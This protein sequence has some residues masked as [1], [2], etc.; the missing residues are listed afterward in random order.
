MRSRLCNAATGSFLPK[1]KKWLSWNH[2]IGGMMFL[3]IIVL[4]IS[5][6]AEDLARVEAF[7][8]PRRSEI[9]PLWESNNVSWSGNPKMRTI[10]CPDSGKGSGVALV[11][12]LEDHFSLGHMQMSFVQ[13]FA[14]LHQ[15]RNQSSVYVTYD[16]PDPK[17]LKII[18]TTYYDPMLK[19]FVEYAETQLKIHVQQI[20]PGGEI[21]ACQPYFSNASKVLLY[22]RNCTKQSSG[23][24]AWVGHCASWFPNREIV[25]QW[26]TSYRQTFKK[27][28]VHPPMPGPWKVLVFDRA[29]N[30]KR[31]LMRPTEVVDTLQRT[32][33][34]CNVTYFQF[35]G[36]RESAKSWDWN[37]RLFASY[38]VVVMVHGAATA[39]IICMRPAS[40]LIEITPEP[41][42]YVPLAEQLGL[43]RRGVPFAAGADDFDGLVQPDMAVL[44]QSSQWVFRKLASFTR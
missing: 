26:T 28:P 24:L 13:L 19:E 20:L 3:L 38:D 29:S 36:R 7:V 1:C 6:N 37:C 9:H 14:W 41:S 12:S 10:S 22:N 2:A 27:L 39:N 44:E 30:Y 32:C 31:S 25:K 15:V 18:K 5:Q 8:E 21:R 34:V 4:F 16:R 43:F 42:M 33:L 11:F 35:Q 17:E 40:A 23:N